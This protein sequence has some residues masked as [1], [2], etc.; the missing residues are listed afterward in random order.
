[1]ST[2]FHKPYEECYDDCPKLPEGVHP[3]PRV[4]MEYYR[5]DIRKL[6]DDKIYRLHRSD[7]VSILWGMK[8]E[9]DAD[10]MA[11][12]ILAEVKDWD[13]DDDYDGTEEMDSH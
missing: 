9:P 7:L 1:M 12:K 3:V 5:G 6:K 10:V 4:E 11:N 2:H 13:W 8:F